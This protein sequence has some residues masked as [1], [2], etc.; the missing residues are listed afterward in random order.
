MEYRAERQAR[1]LSRPKTKREKMPKIVSQGEYE[2]RRLEFR[3]K[4]L[5][6][7]DIPNTDNRRLATP[8]EAVKL[9]I[10]ECRADIECSEQLIS[11][12]RGI[13]EHH[14]K[15]LSAL[16]VRLAELEAKSARIAEGVIEL[17]PSPIVVTC[18]PSRAADDD[19]ATQH[20]LGR[21]DGPIRHFHTRYHCRVVRDNDPDS[22]GSDRR[23][24]GRG[25]RCRSRAEL[26]Q[27][28]R[29]YVS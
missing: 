10:D 5:R 14:E 23:G 4:G 13:I 20:T 24:S 8:D 16:S 27:P 1:R 6:Y 17:R 28:G 29:L 3:H 21:R 25:R 19:P 9:D 22:R 11:N 7:I 2:T 18:D 12:S 15:I 26:S